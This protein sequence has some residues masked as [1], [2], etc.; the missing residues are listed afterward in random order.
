MNGIYKVR[1][2]NILYTILLI[3]LLGLLWG[4]ASTTSKHKE[5]L[6]DIQ[7]DTI[8]IDTVIIEQPNPTTLEKEVTIDTLALIDSLIQQAHSLCAQSSFAQAHVHLQEIIDLIEVQKEPL[9]ETENGVSDFLIRISEIYTEAMPREYLDSIPL[10]ISNLI[11]RYQISMAIDTLSISP[12]DS[13]ILKQLDCEEGVPYNVPIVHNRRVQ[14]ALYAVVKK[15]H[16]TLGRILKRANYY[17]PVMQEIFAKHDMPTDLCYLPILESAFNPKA[18]SYAHASGIWQFI[19]STG[20]I[21]GLRKNYWVD[22][23]RD[24]LKSTS[25]A[26]AYLKKLYNDFDDWYLA[27]A[28]YNCGERNVARAIRKAGTNDYW[29]LRLPRQTMNYVPL[30]ISYQ[31]IAKNPQCFGF[32]ADTA[33]TFD[34]DTVQISDCIDLNKI[35]QELS[36]SY[37]ELKKMNPHIWRWCTPPDMKSVTLYIPKGSAQRFK[38]FYASLS[39]KDKVKWY[40]YRIKSGDN[41]LS[42]ARRYRISVGAIKS[43]NKLRNNF[44]IAG[45]HLYIPIPING[46]YPIEK[47]YAHKKGSRHRKPAAKA[48][49]IAAFKKAGKKPQ[50]HQVKAGQTLSEIA[51]QYSTSIRK[52]CQWNGISNP[53]RIRAGTTLKLYVS[54]KKEIAAVKMGPHKKVQHLHKYTY[55]VKSGDNLYLISRRLKVSMEN[56]A[57]WNQKSLTHPIIKPGEQLIYYI[58]PS[59]MQKQTLKNKPL[60]GAT[61]YTVKKGDNLYSIAAQLGINISHLFMLNNLDNNSIIK[62]GDKLYITKTEKKQS[63]SSIEKSNVVLYTVKKGDNLWRIASS[64]GIPVSTLLK[65]NKLKKNAPLLPGDIIRIDLSEDS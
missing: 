18:Y 57:R 20:R 22:E 59:S 13:I 8:A 30:Y 55:T 31:I 12:R 45:R 3:F 15:R 53:R 38:D 24:P 52:I 65:S 26:I 14:N 17:L 10:N 27:L 19:P 25:A 60:K 49:E 2:H 32:E 63:L 50:L 43:I 46:S 29:Q 62:P 40:R 42:I 6:S 33:D 64:F 41:L 21:Y 5:S 39:D 36:I 9:E 48:P 16:R 4:C 1:I 56:L 61:L 44:I 58:S 11:Y 51:E 47:S 34:F 35:A 28:A 7:L 54:G 37:S 23:R